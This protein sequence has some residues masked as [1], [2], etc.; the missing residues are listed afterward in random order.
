MRF[1]ESGI[2]KIPMV[3]LKAQEETKNAND[4]FLEYFEDNLIKTDDIDG[5]ISDR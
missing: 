4:G 5:K 1:Y 2:S 3:F